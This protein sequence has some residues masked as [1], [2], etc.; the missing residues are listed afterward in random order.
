MY[1]MYWCLYVLVTF[2]SLF[3]SA[4]R[5][6]AD[7]IKQ[8]HHYITLLMRDPSRNLAQLLPKPPVVNSQVNRTTGSG[9]A[10]GEPPSAATL[11]S[12]ED[13]SDALPSKGSTMAASISSTMA[14]TAA[15]TCRQYLAIM[16]VSIS[17][18]PLQYNRGSF[19]YCV[20]FLFVCE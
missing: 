15:G 12:F 5:G 14:A 20:R 13:V 11:D 9:G 7:A 4:N 3:C 17:L 8:A 10:G 2:I 19:A 18:L 6:S 16:C 1:V